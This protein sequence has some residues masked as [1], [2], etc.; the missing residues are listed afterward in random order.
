VH[1]QVESV[2]GDP[3]DLDAVLGALPAPTPQRL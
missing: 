1:R 2:A 3:L